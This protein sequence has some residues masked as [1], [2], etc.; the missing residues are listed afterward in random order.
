MLNFHPVIHQMYNFQRNRLPLNDM[1]FGLYHGDGLQHQFLQL[2]ERQSCSQH[3]RIPERAGN[4]HTRAHTHKTSV[5]HEQGSAG[6]YLLQLGDCVGCVII[7]SGQISNGIFV[8]Y[9]CWRVGF[10]SFRKCKRKK[11]A[12]KHRSSLHQRYRTL[13]WFEFPK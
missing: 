13:L 3:L 6:A 8:L 1:I 10:V 2:A 4:T 12:T 7:I 11:Y 9:P 5:E